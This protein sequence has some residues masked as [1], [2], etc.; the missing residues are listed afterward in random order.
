MPYRL[1]PRNDDFSLSRCCEHKSCDS[2]SLEDHIIDAEMCIK[3]SQDTNAENS[4]SKCEA[5]DTS[6]TLI[7][8]NGAANGAPNVAVDNF[9][10]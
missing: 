2:S 3:E 8:K 10:L 9:S 7:N 4:E 1:E 5:M 6:E